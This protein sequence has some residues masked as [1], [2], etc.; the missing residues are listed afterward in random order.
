MS[1][2]FSSPAVFFKQPPDAN[3]RR[4]ARVASSRWSRGRIARCFT[5]LSLALLLAGSLAG[6]LGAPLAHAAVPTL[7]LPAAGGFS[8]LSFEGDWVQ[9][10]P[11]VWLVFCSC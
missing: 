1:R 9:Q 7:P 11:K 5:M 4:F 10:H 8:P 3:L 2:P 6:W